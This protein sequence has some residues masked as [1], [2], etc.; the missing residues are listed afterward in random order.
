MT[1]LFRKRL[2]PAECIS[3]KDDQIIHI[4]QN[5]I[6]T[7]W[8][9]FRPKPDFS[10]GISYYVLDKGWKISKFF[11]NDNTLAY[12]YCDIIDTNYDKDSDT[13]VFT[14]LLADVI[15]KE[16]NIKVVDLDELADACSQG[17]ISNEMLVSSLHKLNNLLTAIYDESFNEY[18]EVLNKYM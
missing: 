2:I 6:I 3:L 16:N 14:D 11:K 17:L 5:Q 13:Y 18:L 4:E 10:H 15:I 12:I 1:A 9:T 7:K 8:Q